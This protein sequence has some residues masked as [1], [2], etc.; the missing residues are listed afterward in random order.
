MA[1][2]G[3]RLLTSAAT[4]WF[5]VFARTVESMVFIVVL[6]IVLAVT[7]VQRHPP[8]RIT[9]K[10]KLF[11][12]SGKGTGWQKAGTGETFKHGQAR[13]RRSHIA[14]NGV[15][16]ASWSAGRSRWRSIRSPPRAGASR[17]AN[18]K[19]RSPAHSTSFA[20]SERVSTAGPS[21]SSRR[22]LPSDEVRSEHPV[23]RSSRTRLAPVSR[24]CA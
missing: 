24:R 8:A 7:P 15:A 20:G 19:R 11:L 18:P 13:M 6:L 21:A 17:P 16:P 1:D 14:C 4:A 23:E 9:N 5:G 22:R 12:R 3:I 2:R 10:V